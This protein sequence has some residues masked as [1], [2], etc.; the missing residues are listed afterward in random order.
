MDTGKSTRCLYTF[1]SSGGGGNRASR[2]D[3]LI[4]TSSSTFIASNRQTP[5]PTAA[6]NRGNERLARTVCCAQHANGGMRCSTS[7][8][9][10]CCS[11]P[12]DGTRL[13]RRWPRSAR[14]ITR[15][16]RRGSHAMSRIQ[17]AQRLNSTIGASERRELLLGLPLA[18]QQGGFRWRGSALVEPALVKAT[19]RWSGN[20]L[21]SGYLQ[22]SD[23]S[24]R[25]RRDPGPRGR[26]SLRRIS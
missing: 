2:P 12:P 6:R 20:G 14:I 23:W 9:C 16:S 21:V 7:T 19:G 4:G 26:G 22:S 13:P 15:C 11:T 3:R 8:R 24:S 25:P 1:C 18:V 10:R 17:R 5:P